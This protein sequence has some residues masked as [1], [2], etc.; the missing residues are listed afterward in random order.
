LYYGTDSDDD[1]EDADSDD[2]DDIGMGVPPQQQAELSR[3][4]A[5]LLFVSRLFYP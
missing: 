1:D 4:S 5:L 3:V 2:D